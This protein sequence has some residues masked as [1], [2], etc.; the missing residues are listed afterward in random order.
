M[1]V[2]SQHNVSYM[3]GNQR[4]AYIDGTK[5]VAILLVV[6][7]HC[8]CFEL[9][10]K[11][12]TLKIIFQVIYSFHMPLFFLLAGFFSKGIP[13]RESVPKYAKAYLKPFII[14]CFI[15]L[16]F[17]LGDSIYR[18]ASSA[19]LL[20]EVKQ[21]ALFIYSGCRTFTSSRQLD[22]PWL[23]PLWFLEA[24]FIAKVVYAWML[25][26]LSI[27]ESTVMA[28]ALFLLSLVS[29]HYYPRLPLTLQASA[30]AVLFLHVGWLIRHYDVEK[31]FRAMH[32]VCHVAALFIWYLCINSI[33]NFK[34][35]LFP[36]HLLHVLG[37]AVPTLLLLWLCQRI[38]F[39][40][41]WVGRNTLCI[42]CAHVIA[43]SAQKYAYGISSLTSLPWVNFL[44][45]SVFL[46]ALT[47]VFAWLLYASRLIRN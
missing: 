13:L 42:L 36:Y 39:S 4:I 46:I 37:G 31:A 43:Q 15:V 28:L 29:T 6:V 38:G 45:E 1:T 11:D 16:L 32:P 17:V 14:T 26:R 12:L 3:A 22:H 19:K 9:Y 21:W 34:G 27:M 8:Y 18:G 25:H 5:A 30:L 41:G 20:S 24:I 40:G 7:G 10:P 47:A 44:I 35:L 33:F 2:L 23:G